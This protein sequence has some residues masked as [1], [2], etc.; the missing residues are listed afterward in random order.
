MPKVCFIIGAS[1]GIGYACAQKF[2]NEGYT[3]V[4]GSRTPCNID[5][6]KNYVVDVATPKTIFDAVKDIEKNLKRIDTLVYSAGYS[7]AAP[8]EYVKE[9]DYRYLFDVNYFGA[10]EAVRAVI[11]TM[12]KQ[13]KGTLILVSS[14]GGIMPIAFDSF[15]SSAK[16]AVNMLVRGLNLELAPHNIRAISVMPG[17]TQTDFTAN[18]NVYTEEEAGLYYDRM[19]N[20]VERLAKIEQEGMLPERVAEVIYECATAKKTPEIVSVGVKNKAFHMFDRLM[21]RMETRML[22]RMRYRV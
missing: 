5:G 4:N 12:K 9:D 6:V 8:V 3:V 20:A 18:R 19:D 1:S 13:G 10:I 17:G 2:M 11:P 22:L 7:M 14:I 21:P 15:Y 16:A